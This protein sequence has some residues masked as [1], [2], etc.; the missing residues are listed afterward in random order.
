MLLHMLSI[1]RCICGCEVG[2]TSLKLHAP[3]PTTSLERMPYLGCPILGIVCPNPFYWVPHQ[4]KLPATSLGVQAL[5]IQSHSLVEDCCK[6]QSCCKCNA[7]E[8]K[9][10]S[11]WHMPG[12]HVPILFVFVFTWVIRVCS[13]SWY[14]MQNSENIQLLQIHT[15][16]NSLQQHILK[17]DKLGVQSLASGVQRWSIC[18]WSMQSI[19]RG[20]GSNMSTHNVHKPTKGKGDITIS[21]ICVAG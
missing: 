2:V 10:C 14:E 17:G 3:A 13:H 11:S 19:H 20:V 8:I 16:T 9:R 18:N 15:S 7:Y 1:C 5:C 4:L 21:H 6:G 12:S